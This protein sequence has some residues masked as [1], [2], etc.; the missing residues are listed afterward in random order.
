[1]GAQQFRLSRYGENASKRKA[2]KQNKAS[3]VTFP[4]NFALA[5]ILIPS[6]R[7]MR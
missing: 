7:F 4:R 2:G 5:I 3:K 6:L 1:L